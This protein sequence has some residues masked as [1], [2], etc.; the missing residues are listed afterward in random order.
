MEKRNIKNLRIIRL[1]LGNPKGNL[2]KYGIAKLAGCSKPWVIEF[3]RKIEERK[4]VRKTKVLDFNKLADYYI[5]IMPK[6][7]HFEFF[8]QEPLK[9]LKESK[10]DYALTTY[11]AENFTSRHLFLSR[12]D[13]Y[14]KEGDI[15][16]WKSL[17]IKEGLL[18]KGNLRLVL[19]NDPTI[20]KEAKE[21]KGIR[22]VS[23]PLLL[24]DLKKEGGV[25]MEAYNILVKGNV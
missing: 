20:F 18:G 11:G 17:I 12:Y 8:V 7:K 16:K 2:T 19:A 4:I 21:I 23:M 15:D 13:V 6:T 25:C 9:L 14:I 1:L 22:I 24:I 5:G 10:L 3:L